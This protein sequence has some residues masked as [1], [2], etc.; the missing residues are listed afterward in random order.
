MEIFEQFF[1]ETPKKISFFERKVFLPKNQNII[2]SGAPECGKTSLAILSGIEKKEPYIYMDFNDY[3]LSDT[4]IDINALYRFAASKKITTLILDGYADDAILADDI[5]TIIIANEQKD[6]DGYTNIRLFGLDFEE[7]LAFYERVYHGK[8]ESEFEDEKVAHTFANFIK[9]G[10]SPKI[11]QTNE[12]DKHHNLSNAIRR[13]AKTK[14]EEN[15]LIEFL[16]KTSIKLS[17]LQ[18]FNAL[19]AK[20]K[21]SKDFFYSYTQKLENEGVIFFVEKLHQRNSPKKIYSYD[22]ALKTA[23]DFKKDFSGIFENMVFLELNSRGYEVY[24]T[25]EAGFFVPELEKAIVAKPFAAINDEKKLAKLS[26]RAEELGI[27]EVEVVTV[28]GSDDKNINGI[29]IQTIPFWQWALSF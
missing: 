9:D 8:K 22:F 5:Q 26:K 27:K 12:F 4:K 10:T 18:V 16:R 13:I 24:Y 7:Y 3:R 23:V 29:S 20:G 19:K 1:S 17:L 21:I 2:L 15:I 6:I 14:T 11:N 28:S 25:D